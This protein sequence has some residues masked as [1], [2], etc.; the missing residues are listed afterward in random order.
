MSVEKLSEIDTGLNFLPAG[1]LE[2]LINFQS[3][4]TSLT[5]L[6]IANASLLDEGTAAAEAMVIAFGHL[7]EKK[8]TFF[9]DRSVLPQTL[10]VVRTRAA[11]FGIKVVVGN[12]QKLLS[13]EDGDAAQ[14]K[15]LMGVLVQYPEMRGEVTD[16]KAVADRTH[17]LGGLVTCAT[18]FLALTMLK[19]PGE[20]GADMA[21]G[22]S[23]RFGVPMAYGGP[24]AAF[25]ACTDTLKRRIPGRLI[26]L[27]K[28]AQGKPA[29]RLAL[30]TREQHIR[31]DKAT[32]NICTAQ[33]LLA[34]V[35]SMYAVY[36]GPEGLRQIAEKVHGLAR[37]V[38][39]GVEKL[40][41][42]VINESF[43]DNLTIRLNGTAA[44]MIHQEA[45]RKQI[46][47]RPVD[48]NHVAISFDESN[49]L[50]DIVDLLNVFVAVKYR[51]KTRP[52]TS[53]SLI[54]Y[55]NTLNIAAPRPTS[56]ALGV[57][58]TGANIPPIESPAIPA[59][60][61]RTSPFLTQ[62]VW[63]VHH[64]ETDILRYMHHLQSKDLSLVHAMM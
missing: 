12:V 2:S 1:R 37:V 41:H 22:N 45:A 26:G 40:G 54:E 57:A 13:A 18:D 33:A 47:L 38:K 11:P 10:E 23:A 31:R 4:T 20:W 8:K 55:A 48:E 62:P 24:H 46:N 29:Y 21:F 61:A 7:R 63:N 34:N 3:L 30:Q 35:A 58:S 36:H 60:L 64:S 49:T 27:S 15:D 14:Q 59:H 39:A 42:K 5:G 52:Y 25:F 53:D 51:S 28:D 32:S 19:P 6:D 17:E 43:F 16:W 50:E 56:T 44:S 9:V